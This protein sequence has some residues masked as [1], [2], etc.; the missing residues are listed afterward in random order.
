MII[1]EDNR[2]ITIDGID[3][4]KIKSYQV[5]SP[6]VLQTVV[7]Q[8]M[9]SD[10]VRAALCEYLSNGIDAHRE[11]Q[12]MDS[13]FDAAMTPLAVHFQGSQI[14]IQDFGVGIT[15]ERMENNFA[16]YFSSTK[17]GTNDQ[18]GGFG[19][20]CKTAFA[21][22]D[23]DS[24]TVDTVYESR[25]GER[26]FYRTYH[27]IDK[28]GLTSYAELQHD[29][30]TAETGTKIVLPIDESKLDDFVSTLREICRYWPVKPKIFGLPDFKWLQHEPV[31]RGENWSFYTTWT[32]VHVVVEGIPYRLPPHHYPD[33][34]KSHNVGFA[35]HFRTGE[36]GLTSTRESIDFRGDTAVKITERIEEAASIIKEEMLRKVSSLTV[37]EQASV[38]RTFKLSIDGLEWAKNGALSIR[39]G[40]ALLVSRFG[41]VIETSRVSSIPVTKSD[42]R[43]MLTRAESFRKNIIGKAITAFRSD[44]SIEGLY[45]LPGFY[46]ED[47]PEN[48]ARFVEESL[49]EEGTILGDFGKFL[50]HT[51]LDEYQVDPGYITPRKPRR[52]VNKFLFVKSGGK[53][54]RADANMD[55]PKRA[56]YAVFKDSLK[57]PQCQVNLFFNEHSP[58]IRFAVHAKHKKL[59]PSGWINVKKIFQDQFRSAVKKQPGRIA[60][61]VPG[62]HSLYSDRSKPPRREH[63]PKAL[64][65]ILEFGDSD[66]RIGDRTKQS[67]VR[68]D[69]LSWLTRLPAPV[70]LNNVVRTYPWDRQLLHRLYL[71]VSKEVREFQKEHVSQYKKN[72]KRTL[73][74]ITEQLA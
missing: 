49:G 43:I 66:F 60:V 44:P 16:A 29:V 24:F 33:V 15:K 17:R 58:T 5:G 23:R 74:R 7:R 10:P 36:I 56:V 26:F 45:V 21:D 46:G 37:L 70:V 71:E 54:V 31:S 18:I 69:Y 19:L 27:F 63:F 20:G 2:R 11:R 4:S 32:G 68:Q 13:Q 40:R 59:I 62:L 51:L 53:W 61:R 64:R 41:H 42:I 48:L 6:V 12:L 9:Y 30:T 14:I 47:S 73:S 65:K 38:V 39:R 22:P 25:S 1:A 55:L 8:S 50:C 28:T 35:V 57:I 3:P 52:K 72:L 67:R 34:V